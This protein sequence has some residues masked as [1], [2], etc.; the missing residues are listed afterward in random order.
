MLTEAM[1][2]IPGF[3]SYFSFSRLRSGY[4]GV[5]TFCR[6]SVTPTAA[7]TS[8]TG[9]G[10]TSTIGPGASCPREEFSSKELR[11]LDTEGRCVVTTDQAQAGGPEKPGHHQRVLPPG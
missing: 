2:I 8:L 10:D 5:A 9:T 3:T 1:A 11:S 4:S 6:M 7:E